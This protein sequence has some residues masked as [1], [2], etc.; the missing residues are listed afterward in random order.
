MHFLAVKLIILQSFL[1][2]QP[3]EMQ[4]CPLS[5]LVLMAKVLDIGAPKDLLGLALDPPKLHNIESTILNLKEVRCFF[6]F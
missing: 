1:E 6:I 5:K 2:E 4:R 3:P